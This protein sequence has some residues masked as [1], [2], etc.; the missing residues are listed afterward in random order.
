MRSQMRNV[1]FALRKYWLKEANSVFLIN[2]IT[3]S[4]SSALEDGAQ[5]MIEETPS[6]TSV[7]AL[8]VVE[9]V[10]LS[11]PQPP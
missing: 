6:I 7:H 1:V 11:F 4:V 9:T 2:V 5:P 10:S 8:F 3:H